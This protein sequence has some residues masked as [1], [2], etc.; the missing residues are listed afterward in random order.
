MLLC[1]LPCLTPAYMQHSRHERTGLVMLKWTLARV[2]FEL[3]MICK[4]CTLE[5]KLIKAHIM[6]DSMNR[7]LRAV[8]GDDPNSSMLS[9][10]KE[11]GLTKRLPVRNYDKTIICSD[12]DGSFSVWET[13]ALDVLFR[14]HAWADQQKD[15]AGNPVCYTLLNGDYGALKLFVLQRKSVK[16]QQLEVVRSILDRDGI[17][18][19]FAFARS[20][21][22]PY[23]VGEALANL[24]LG[25]TIEERILR[26][27]LA[28]DDV[29]IAQVVQTVAW[30]RLS[31]SGLA[32]VS[33]WLRAE[34]PL[35][36]DQQATLLSMC[37]PNEEV[38]TLVD[39]RDD[40]T[41]AEYWRRML[42]YRASEELTELIAQKL[43]AHRR[44][45]M[46][47]DLLASQHR[48][49]KPLDADVV[50]SV[51]ERI[52]RPEDGDDPP[53]QIIGHTI[54]ELLEVVTEPGRLPIAR[55]ASLEWAYLPSIG[56]FIRRPKLLHRA[57]ADDPGFFIEMLSLVFRAADEEKREGNAEDVAKAR[58][59]YELLNTWD[60]I[61]GTTDSGIDSTTLM[62]W[63][64]DARERAAATN[65][66]MVADLEIGEMLGRGSHGTP[67]PPAAV[68][69]VLEE[70]ESDEIRRGFSI[71]VS[72]L[73][74][75]TSRGLEDGGKQ[76]RGLAETYRV[77]A[78][79]IADRWPHAAAVVA[80]IADDYDRHARREDEHAALRQGLES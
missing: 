32:W 57:L 56:R 29:A 62:A 38:L 66:T 76:E 73:R 71:G 58:A 2:R 70:I 3:A 8:L 25:T 34:P 64:G 10:E 75:M 45:H 41:Q 77:H 63:V 9:I 18:A 12:C 35:R 13:H 31:R 51:L 59:A 16:G 44:P 80:G 67:W 79:E 24:D 65:R 15:R 39:G 23:E 7:V 61:P 68:C 20:V 27:H 78:A 36:A 17:K 37:D 47:L 40:T 72:N 43:V 6:P 28:D 26:D 11:S 48:R 1:R 74:G 50:A 49:K 69:E 5:K 33:A 60:I 22:L 42:P 46:A 53:G 30:S 4:L 52:L 21:A 54:G 55:A 14:K 19:V